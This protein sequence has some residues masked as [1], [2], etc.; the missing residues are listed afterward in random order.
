M[1]ISLVMILAGAALA[2][3]EVRWA[4]PAPLPP[5][6]G[7]RVTVQT[8]DQLE[9]AVHNLTSDTTILVAPGT[10]RLTHAINLRGGLHNV[11]I[12][13][14]SRNRDR[15]VI[16]GHGHDNKEMADKVPHCIMVS[17]AE[18]VV[19]ADLSLGDVYFHAITLQG[20]SGCK[21]VLVHNVR[22]FDAGEQCL[23]SNPAPDGVGVPD[24]T[25]QY[26]LFEYI[27]R[28]RHDYINGINVLGTDRWRI[29]HNVFRNIRAPQGQLAG[30]SILMWVMSKNTVCQNNL[31]VNCQRGIAYGLKEGS[32]RPDHEGG[33]IEGNIFYR[34][35]EH[36]GDAAIH[37]WDCPGT[38]IVGNTVVLS[39][40][41]P[42][43]IE[44]RFER[45]KDVLIENNICD[46]QILQRDGGHAV[47]RN[48]RKPTEEEL[49]ELHERFG[50]DLYR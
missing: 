29:Q 46:A 19:I 23:K 31:F 9:N 32:P 14:L 16:I 47:V 15:A 30:P 39:G 24:V 22:M 18:D 44:Y 36:D 12:R 28:P 2:A 17:E 49:A 20:Q 45:T 33:L 11:G 27:K 25:I 38:K 4:K 42:A 50:K 7:K 48:N 26:C 6:R 10:Y 21:K 43:G 5:I 41:Y 8:V 35:A 3:E 37:A 1:Q 13:G 34:D 40:T